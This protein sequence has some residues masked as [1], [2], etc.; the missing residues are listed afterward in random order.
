M[1]RGAIAEVNLSAIA[2]NLHSIRKIVKNRPVIAVVKADAYG[3]GAVE[4]S[5]RLLKEGVSCIAVA[6]TGEAV[7]LRE[8]GIN[9]PIIVLFDSGDIKDFFDFNLIPVIYNSVD[10]VSKL[11]AEARKRDTTIKVQ[12]KVDT[13]MGRLGLY[14][15][16]IID[17]LVRIS[18]MPGIE[19]TGLLSHFSEADLSDRTYAVI[20]L[21]RFNQIRETICKKLKRKIFSHIANS[22]AVLTFEDAHLDAVRPGLMLYGYSPFN[23][24]FNPPIPPLEKGGKGGFELVNLLPAMKV[25]AKIL[26]IRNLPSGTPI[27]YGRTFITRRPSRIGVLPLGYA[28]G[29]SRIFSNNA[30]VLVKGRRVPI[31]GRVCMDLTMTDLTDVEDVTENDEV[32]I[33]GQQ[34]QESITAQE[35]AK[36][37]NTIPYEILTSFGSRSRKTF[38]DGKT[39]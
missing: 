4:V 23:Q 33:M 19:L 21:N 14:D 11:S 34:E 22:A 13:G 27:S 38:I 26:C 28:D 29:Y 24:N 5:K 25:K 31:V 15:N 9:I 7:Q 16:H 8:A 2:N 20:Q 18:E 36:R 30:E 35:L 10:T 37:A 1:I 17:D 39:D 6:Y 3:H 32:I 12:V